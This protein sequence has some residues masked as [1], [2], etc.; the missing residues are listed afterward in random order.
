MRSKKTKKRFVGCSN[1]PDCTTTYPLP[2]VGGI[3]ATNETCPECG[4]PRIKIITKGKRPWTLCLDPNCPT[5]QKKETAPA[6]S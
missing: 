6:E 5:K 3:L 4:S 1:Y 2:Q